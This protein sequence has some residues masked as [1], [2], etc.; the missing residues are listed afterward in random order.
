MS[1]YEFTAN[2]MTV[3]GKTFPVEFSISTD[4]VTVFVEMGEGR[5]NEKI[6]FDNTHSDYEKVRTAAEAAAAAWKLKR[7][8]IAEKRPET[9]PESVADAAPA[10]AE[11]VR[12]EA[13][14][15]TEETE[16]KTMPV[17][18]IG[19]DNDGIFSI[20]MIQAPDAETARA[21]AE[22][23]AARYGYTVAYISELAPCRVKENREKGMPFEVVEERPEI[24]PEAESA[25]EVVKIT[26]EE[27]GEF[28]DEW[29]C[30]QL[31][32]IPDP[33][34]R[35][36]V[37]AV[38]AAFPAVYD[39]LYDE[40]R[41]GRADYSEDVA[42]FDAWLKTPVCRDFISH[43]ANVRGDIFS[44]DREAAAFVAACRECNACRENERPETV[45]ETEAET[46]EEIAD[47]RPENIPESAEAE[48]APE[49]AGADTGRPSREELN[50]G[51]AT[52]GPVPEKNFAGEAISGK[53]WAIVF[54]TESNRTRVIISEKVKEI[55]VPII[56]AAG[57]YYSKIS[58]SWNKKLTHRAHRAALA[59]AD[60]L[61]AALA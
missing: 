30:A 12:P 57:F 24:I 46:A 21:A 56:E 10:D 42:L 14:S 61:R 11:T 32:A 31:D 16:E 20:N 6:R 49:D 53:G 18:E 28:E 40:D 43:C 23:H 41:E 27:L 7:E 52:R 54:D 4:S 47:E 44:S 45:P 25:P 55:A 60:D 38:V 2:T 9:V 15:E 13:I 8:S 37:A 3:N 51:K 22:A 34:I 1:N 33:D 5:K 58:E 29:T 26:P 48:A 17:F 35:E 50:A 39:R 36:K 59:L 19:Y